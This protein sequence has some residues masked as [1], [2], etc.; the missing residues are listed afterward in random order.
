MNAPMLVAWMAGLAWWLLLPH[1]AA[2][3]RP[4]AVPA[5]AT[6]LAGRP[7]APA[8]RQRGLAGGCAGTLVAVAIGGWIGAAFGVG[9]VLAVVV[10]LGRAGPRPDDGELRVELPDALDFLAACLEAG[11]PLSQAVPAVAAVSPAATGRLLGTVSARL[12]AGL[13][14]GEAWQELRDHAVWGRVAADVGGA[15]RWGTSVA[16]LLRAHADDTRRGQEDEA[17]RRARTV[18]VRSVLPL[19][20]CFLPAFILVGVVPIVAGLV[21]NLLV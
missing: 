8:L 11:L 5:P 10:L 16:G 6:W 3:L 20:L 14:S 13:S 21:R 15:Q 9:C 4:A 7:G 18:G 1:P 12:A 17:M 19:M 2:R